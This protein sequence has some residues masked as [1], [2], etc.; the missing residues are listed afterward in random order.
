MEDKITIEK[1]ITNNNVYITM[2][3]KNDRIIGR[4]DY[5]NCI[6]QNLFIHHDYRHH[7]YGSLLLKAIHT[8]MRNNGCKKCCVEAFPIDVYN[9]EE[10]IRLAT[11]DLHKFYKNNG[12]KYTYWPLHRVLP[13]FWCD[14]YKVLKN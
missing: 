2:H 3:I 6:L 7:G 14:M 1:N 12:Y 9:C 10:S 13:D 4:A 8:D 5:S 11:H